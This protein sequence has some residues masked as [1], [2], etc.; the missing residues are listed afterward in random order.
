[1]S[2]GFSSVYSKK[3]YPFWHKGVGKLGSKD[4]VCVVFP[5]V[6]QKTTKE[7]GLGHRVVMDLMEQYQ[8]KGHCLFIDN[9]YT[10]PQLLQDLLTIGIYCTGTI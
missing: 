10:S 8:M 6:Y 5:S 9:F 2:S 7:K 4:W 3:A 1:M